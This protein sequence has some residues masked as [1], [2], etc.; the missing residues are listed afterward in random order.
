M[1]RFEF[2]VG[3]HGV[4]KTTLANKR[5]E[6]LLES[7]IKARLV[8]EVARSCP[9][10]IYSGNTKTSIEAQRWMVEKQLEEEKSALADDYQVVIFDRSLVDVYAYTL[11][12]GYLVYAEKVQKKACRQMAYLERRAEITV[13]HVLINPDLPLVDDG[14]RSTDA[15]LQKQ[16]QS[17]ISDFL[18]KEDWT[19]V[20]QKL[21]G[22]KNE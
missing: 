10:P 5:L 15:N 12:G 7:G 9:F 19:H 11:A 20:T 6:T 4:G 16:I 17:I 21:Q 22:G 14:V 8:P 1:K 18:V 2:F 3:A 13:T